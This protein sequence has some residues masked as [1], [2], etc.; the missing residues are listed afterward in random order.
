M[1]TPA[2]AAT[3]NTFITPKARLSFPALVKPN[4]LSNKYE[5][6]LL[7]KKDD[8]KVMAFIPALRARCQAVATE[9]F[10]AAAKSAKWNPIK[11]G[12]QIFAE[13]PD[14]PE[15]AGHWVITSRSKDPVPCLGGDRKHL[16][17]EALYA[18]CYVHAKVS[19]FGYAAQTGRGVT[20]GLEALQFAGDGE[21]FSGRGPA[22]AGFD[23]I[24]AAPVEAPAAN[25]EAWN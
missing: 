18:G 15:Y 10:G 22:E 9:K 7:L 1:S 23:V 3:T 19:V 25:D 5:V 21:R 6:N 24:E 12:D 13:K 14:R 8:P 16:N 2:Q 4:A 20:T 17:P 11:D